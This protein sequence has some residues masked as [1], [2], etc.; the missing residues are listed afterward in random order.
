MDVL[1]NRHRALIIPVVDDVLDDVRVGSARHFLEEVAPNRR[2][3]DCNP[4][5]AILFLASSAIWG[6]SNTIPPQVGIRLQDTG[7]QRTVSSADVHELAKPREIVGHRDR[8]CC[9]RRES[10]HRLVED[11]RLFRI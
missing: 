9:Y 6:K 4:S 11:L 2:Q 1:K 3:R 5:S 8:R 7:Q 10:R